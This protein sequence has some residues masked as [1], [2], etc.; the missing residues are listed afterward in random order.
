VLEEG[1]PLLVLLCCPAVDADLAVPKPVQ[2]PADILGSDV[3]AG[4]APVEVGSHVLLQ[5]GFTHV[6][7]VQQLI[8]NVIR[9]LA[10]T[11]LHGAASAK[12]V[13]GL[14][15]VGSGCTAVLRDCPGAG[16]PQQIV[17][18]VVICQAPPEPKVYNQVYD[19]T[20]HRGLP[21]VVLRGHTLR[22]LL[23]TREHAWQ[24]E[25]HHSIIYDKYVRCTRF[26]FL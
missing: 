4:V 7:H 8:C 1:A 26:H 16:D 25:A 23:T 24:K 17:G 15:A 10:G 11:P 3:A 13:H 19:V 22:S 21:A 9:D 12:L 2:A 20:V 18:Y 14:P 5:H 6:H